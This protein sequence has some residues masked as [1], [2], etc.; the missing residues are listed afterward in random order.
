MLPRKQG[1][2]PA[3][4]ASLLALLIMIAWMPL[5][6]RQETPSLPATHQYVRLEALLPL[7]PAW[8]QVQALDA[9][10]RIFPA[11]KAQASTLKYP[12]NPL[13]EVFTPPVTV[14]PSLA[15]ERERRVQED[16]LHFVQQTEQALTSKNIDIM[17]RFE[18]IEKRQTAARYSKALADRELQL[19]AMKE[20]EADHLQERINTLGLRQVGLRTQIEA[21]TVRLNQDPRNPVVQDVVRQEALVSEQMKT[22]DAQ[23][24]AVLKRDVRALAVQQLSAQRK[25]WQDES[26]ARLQTRKME[27]ADSVRQQVEQARARLK[28][29][30]KPIPPLASAPLPPAE[31]QATPLPLPLAPDAAEAISKAQ[32]QV[33]AAMGQQQQAL[34]AQ[35]EALIAAIRSDTTQAVAQIARKE[36]WNMV[37]AGRNG[38]DVT[39]QAAGALRNQWRQNAASAR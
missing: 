9:S 3:H 31:P 34:Q 7:H 17:R 33:D 36:G 24:K 27:L 38:K 5:G 37:T 23:R 21:Y 1:G 18:R 22:L 16:A 10:E 29:D 19:N 8:A 14:P 4:R 26:D 11:A 15:A 28:N 39:E 25:Q 20:Q 6:C 30:I 35:R 2:A 13:P 12:Q 32:G